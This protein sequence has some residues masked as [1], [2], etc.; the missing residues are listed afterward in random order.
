MERVRTWSYIVT[1][2]E[3][4]YWLRDGV[5]LKILVFLSHKIKR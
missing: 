4:L 3:L 1:R 5:S 2:K